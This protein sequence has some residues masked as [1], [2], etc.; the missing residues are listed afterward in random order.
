MCLTTQA[1]SRACTGNKA[2]QNME[3]EGQA[4]M[5]TAS[6]KK[7]QRRTFSQLDS[8]T[9]EGEGREQNKTPPLV[10]LKES[11]NMLVEKKRSPISSLN[12]P[13]EQ[14]KIPFEDEVHDYE[15]TSQVRSHDLGQSK[16]YEEQEA[17]KK[18]LSPT[19]PPLRPKPNRV[20]R[21]STTDPSSLGQ[22]EEGMMRFAEEVLMN[23]DAAT[24]VALFGSLLK[25]LEKK[26]GLNH[27]QVARCYH[28]IGEACLYAGK[29][30]LAVSHLEEAISIG[31]NVLGPHHLDVARSLE[32][33]AEANLKLDYVETSH[34]EYRR[35]LRIKR[36]HLGLYH[37]E[38]AHIHTQ[39]AN[40]YF[41]CGEL[42]S[43]QA[44]FEEAL[45]SFRH[46][47]MRAPCWTVK[48]AE[49]LCSIGSIEL[50]RNKFSKAISFFSEASVIQK[51]FHG[52]IHPSVIITLD[53]L[54]YAHLKCK[55]IKTASEIYE[56]MLHAQFSYH[57]VYN[58]ECYNTLKKL[59]LVYQKMDNLPAAI[60]ATTEAV[61]L[62][63]KTNNDEVLLERT[64]KQL[65]RLRRLNREQLGR[66]KSVA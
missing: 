57:Q 38:V 48:A 37:P 4:F 6:S 51:R 9:M 31:S 32:K 36:S 25:E 24:A 3:Q 18:E 17:A 53:N 12:F 13:M 42:L 1:E 15:T 62:Q 19:K 60:E 29:V 64:M 55:K 27:R 22:G 49:T 35:A 47:S 44:S 65:E 7:N 66:R 58:L 52:V 8:G 20:F 33:S 40:I 54:A 28:K 21:R 61:S 10:T 50:A 41:N 16:S 14:L 26:Y 2:H 46:L 63:K 45:D 23:G 34:R 56:E 11:T 39:L 59:N 43:S 30:E 5:P